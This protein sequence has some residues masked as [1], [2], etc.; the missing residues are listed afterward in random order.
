MKYLSIIVPT[1]NRY[2]F[3]KSIIEKF[4]EE[5]H[6]SDEVEL[7]IQDNSDDNT[8][9]IDYLEKYKDK[10]ILYHYTKDKIDVSTN[11]S[12]AVEVSSG[13]YVSMLGDDDGFTK[14]ILPIT[15][16]LNSN[17]IES[18]IFNKAHYKWPDALIALGS[19]RIFDVHTHA[20]AIHKFDGGIYEVPV[21][22]ELDLVLSDGVTRLARLPEVYH[23]IVS[24]ACL[25]KIKDATGTFFPGSSPD[26]A[27]A[28]SLALTV[29]KHVYIDLPIVF[30]GQNAVSTGGQGM[31]KQHVGALK[32]QPHLSH[33]IEDKWC[34]RIPK[35]W[36][37]QTI[38]AQS[39]F[40]VF[41]AMKRPELLD[42]INWCYLYAKF[43]VDHPDYEFLVKP[44]ITNSMVKNYLKYKIKRKIKMLGRYPMFLM[45]KIT[46][47][48]LDY[49]YDDVKSTK[50]AA[51]IIE[52]KMEEKTIPFL[53]KLT[54]KGA[55]YDP[56][57]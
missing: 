17:G 38:Y 16:Y 36:T 11:F 9:I 29:Q 3:I 27:N 49:S 56:T 52:M 28:I 14:Y 39:A 10:S 24:R 54:E 4:V 22:K 8:E 48:T 15:K 2:K 44:F 19:Q 7:V 37:A 55:N 45:R 1:R 32:D 30:S 43:S 46:N 57:C 5:F 23:G 31:R 6:D 26:M 51:S 33:D 53:I 18:A 34:P 12:I 42:R 13:K 35:I 40:E 41:E 47:K 21:D 20:L 50:D 25:N